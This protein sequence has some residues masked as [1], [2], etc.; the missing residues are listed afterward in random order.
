MR[1]E[2]IDREL[3][4]RQAGY[5]RGGR[6]E[7]EEDQVEILSGIRLGKT[8]GSPVAL[9]LRNLDWENWR[10][11]MSR[12]DGGTDVAPLDTVRPGHADLP[13]ALKYGHRDVRNVIERASARE[14]AARVMAG[15]A[16]KRLL[17]TLGVAVI[18]HVVSL[19]PFRVSKDTEGDPEIAGKAES[20]RLRMADPDAEAQAIQWID[21]MKEAGTTAGGVVEVIATGLPPGLGSFTSWDRRL[22]GRIGQALMSI[23]AIK[24]VEIGDGV[25]LATLPG[26]EALDEIFPGP[27]G[28]NPLFGNRFLPFHRETNRAGGLEGG[29]TNGEFLVVR[30]AMKPIPTQP[31]PLRSVTLGSWESAPAHRE[32]GDVCAVPAAA[33]VAEAM[34]AIVLADAFLEKFGGDTTEDILYNYS[35]YLERICAR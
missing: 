4:R 27:S 30:A 31:E 5:G 13:G 7:I 11:T 28:K 23:H 24:G 34:V 19:G 15:A 1:A 25:F 6:M 22:D 12:E 21:E 14:T 26:K 8:L 9:L 32:R 10:E 18:G 29:M 35:H 33:V 3:R 2:D 17:D 20:S 16:A